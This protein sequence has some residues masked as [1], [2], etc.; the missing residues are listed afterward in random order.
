VILDPPAFAKKK[1]DIIPG[2]RGYKDINRIAMKKMPEGS[3]LLTCSCSHFVDAELFQKVLFQAAIEA[4]REVQILSG[5]ELALDHP[6][7]LS[8][9]EG[10]YLKSFLLYVGKHVYKE[11]ASPASGLGHKGLG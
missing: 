3:L 9:P 6:I 5:H 7:N 11:T 1:K 10:D 8:H 2:C 4:G